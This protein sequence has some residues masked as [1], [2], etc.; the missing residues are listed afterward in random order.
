MFRLKKVSK[1]VLSISSMFR[2][3]DRSWNGRSSG[4][5]SADVLRTECRWLTGSWRTESRRDSPGPRRGVV[6]DED[7]RRVGWKV[8]ASKGDSVSFGRAN[9]LVHTEIVRLVPSIR[10]ILNETKAP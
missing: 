1:A 4:K 7:R 3:A 5:S 2:L 10:R 6:A 8:E 9:S